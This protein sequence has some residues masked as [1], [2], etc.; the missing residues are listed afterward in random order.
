MINIEDA[1]I[2]K[3]I[4]HRLF[5]ES[6][7]ALNDSTYPIR[8]DS[9]SALLRKIFLK[10]FTQLA[11][12]HEFYHPV[13]LKLNV[14]YSLSKDVEQGK[15]FVERSRRI[16]KHLDD[17]SRHP[18]VPGGDLFVIKYKGIQMGNAVYDGLG[19]YKIEQK[20]FFVETAEVVTGTPGL[21]VLQGIG[22]KRFDKACLAVFTEDEAC[23][24]L[25]MEKAG[26][27]TAYWQRDFIGMKSKD[28]NVNHTNRF[29]S[30]TKDFVTQQYPEE[31]IVTK[32]DQI[33]LLN[34][35][36]AFFKSNDHFDKQ[37]FEK[38]VLQDDEVIKSFHNYNLQYS[39]DGADPM[40]NAFEISA[41]VVKKQ[42]RIFKRVLKLDKN[43]HIYIHGNR[44]LIEQGT[45]SDGRK[46][47]KIYFEN[48]T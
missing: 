1:T 23:T 34:R 33:D 15:D 13:E 12:T 46:F 11:A 36:V 16:C 20:D 39:Q 31:F 3:V 28:D 25:V 22:G 44:N 35:S 17:V 47:Y 26:S 42:Q 27:E 38:D 19:I 41:Q 10:P 32:A 5:D 45:D 24:L 6:E 18:G 21:R 4:Y 30:F 9:E 2:E 43:F 48:E 37:S 29:L 40:A 8:D 7:P 14:L